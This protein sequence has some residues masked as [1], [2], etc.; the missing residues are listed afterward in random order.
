MFED[1]EFNYD[2][3]KGS[4]H[5]LMKDWIDELISDCLSFLN[6]SYTP[7]ENYVYLDSQ[8]NYFLN[9]LINS[10]KATSNQ[11]S[12]DSDI[13]ESSPE[14]VYDYIEILFYM[15]SFYNP[16][17]TEIFYLMSKQI[18]ENH[19]E[20]LVLSLVDMFSTL[21]SVHTDVVTQTEFLTI[22]NKLMQKMRKK[23]FKLFT[24]LQKKI[25]VRLFNIGANP[26]KKFIIN[27]FKSVEKGSFFM[28]FFLSSDSELIRKRQ[29]VH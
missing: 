20:T 5:Y 6:L 16:M 19:S 11:S 26:S 28:K 7:I 29:R 25:R 3:L 17:I 10:M 14:I 27:F 13:E 4:V 21:G 8:P 1:E 18:S 2:R 12:F 24:Q 23:N 15:K 9:E 22:V